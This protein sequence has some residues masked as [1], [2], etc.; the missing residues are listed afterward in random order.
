MSTAGGGAAALTGSQQAVIDEFKAL[1]DQTQAFAATF[2]AV[3]TVEGT[4]LKASSE[5][6]NPK[7]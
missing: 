4:E 6:I 1:M 5:Q 2:R 3:S 7:G